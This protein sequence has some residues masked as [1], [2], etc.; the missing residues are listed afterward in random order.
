MMSSTKSKEKS[1]LDRFKEAAREIGTDD[2]E[3]KFNEKLGKLEQVHFMQVRAKLTTSDEGVPY[4]KIYSDYTLDFK[5]SILANLRI[6]S[7]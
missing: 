5:I 1:Q 3:V 2:D 7:E 6:N 4:V